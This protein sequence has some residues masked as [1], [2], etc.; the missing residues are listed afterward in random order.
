MLLVS[1]V[2]SDHMVLQQQAEVPLWGSGTPGES[3]EV[4]SSWG[5]VSNSEVQN[6]GSWSAVLKTPKFG[7][8]FEVKVR[9]GSNEIVFD[10]VFI[11]E[12]WLTS[13]QSN[14]EWP[15]SARLANQADEI[16]N[17][18]YPNIRMFTLPRNLNGSNINTASWKVASSENAPS[19]S[20]VGY[21]F[22]REI[23]QKLGVPI[24]IVN[25]S[26]GGTRVE[27]WTSIEKL[28]SMKE[29]AKGAKE[30]LEQGG[31]ESIKEKAVELNEAS[32]I[33]NEL[34]LKEK[35]YT[36]PKSIEDWNALELGDIQFSSDQYNDADWSEFDF[37]SSERERFTF[38]SVFS[39]NNLE[40]DGVLWIRK[41]FDLDN[42]DEEFSFIVE[43]GI[44]DFDYTYLNGTL[45]GSEFSCCTNRKYDIPKGLLKKEGNVIAIRIID[46][47][48]E[49]GFR[50]PMYLKSGENR[51]AL[52]L[53]KLKYKHTAFFLNNSIQAHNFSTDDLLKDGSSIKNSI[54]EG[55]SI[56]NPNM[57]SILYDKMITPIAPYK[58]KGFLWYQGESNVGN[59]DEYQS[60]FRGMIADWRDKWGDNDLPFY[61]VQ[62]APFI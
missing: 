4:I 25:S 36:V 56:Q 59:F 51:M 34:Y 58:V 30:I 61:F 14:M 28:A 57:Y 3:I 20:A 10:D 49:G 50:G 23:H 7:G 52:D 45:I 62:I 24:G 29:S 38:E 37:D 41:H 2:F 19:F 15:M 39:V 17:A 5:E 55:V 16:K 60:L 27:A 42:P 8:P 46:T 48:G 32:R 33:K 6:N 9:S 22:A 31:L 40:A 13:G 47:G 26:W 43:G 18:N 54:D 21:F 12:V 35:S 44:D 53:G 1:P 11:G